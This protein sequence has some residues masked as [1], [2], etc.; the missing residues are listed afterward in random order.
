MPNELMPLLQ[1]YGGLVLNALN[2]QVPGFEFADNLVRLFGGAT[3]ASIA[4]YGE[5]VLANSMLQ[6]PELRLFGEGRVRK[7]AHE[8]V[9]FEQY[10]EEQDDEMDGDEHHAEAKA[11]A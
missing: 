6:I 10:L 3:H 7:F 9:N 5:Q 8:F 2:T 4:N 11:T 1:A